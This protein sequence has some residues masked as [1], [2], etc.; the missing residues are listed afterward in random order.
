MLFKLKNKFEIK[1]SVNKILTTLLT[2]PINQLY[3][4]G[5]FSRRSAGCCIEVIWQVLTRIY[6]TTKQEELKLLLDIVGE[7]LTRKVEEFINNHHELIFDSSHSTYNQ[8]ILKKNLHFADLFELDFKL[9]LEVKEK[10]IYLKLLFIPCSKEISG[11]SLSIVDYYS[12]KK[13]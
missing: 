7:A 9:K 8:V 13:I 4:E 5:D 2:T 3:T 11:D 6:D 1:N 10:N 12:K